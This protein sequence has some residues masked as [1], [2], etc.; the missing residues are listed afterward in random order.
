MARLRQHSAAF[1]SWHARPASAAAAAVAHAAGLVAF[2]SIC[3]LIAESD[4]SVGILT[5]LGKKVDAEFVVAGETGAARK[6]RLLAMVT[7]GLAHLEALVSL[8]PPHP[9]PLSPLPLPTLI[10]LSLIR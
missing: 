7:D 2:S 10:A 5:M 6:T 4:S 9:A 3:S 1:A 8:P